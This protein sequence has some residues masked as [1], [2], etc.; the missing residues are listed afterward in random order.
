VHYYCMACAVLCR[1]V[2]VF[3]GIIM[4]GTSISIL[5]VDFRCIHKQS[6]SHKR[7]HHKPF[8]ALVQIA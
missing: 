5:A 4:L 2:D 8:T 6:L 7:D 3:R 1:F